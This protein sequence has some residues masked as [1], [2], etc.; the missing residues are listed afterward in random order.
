MP[1]KLIPT[2]FSFVKK[3]ELPDFAIRRIG[4]YAG[5]VDTNYMDK[6]ISSHY[7]IKLDNSSE[8][9]INALKTIT[10]ATNNTVAQ[11]SISKP[12]LTAKYN[13]VFSQIL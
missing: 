6:S 4:V 5:K 3:D 11:K 1:K 13:F 7:F 10:F 2:G 12:E 8:E 9:T